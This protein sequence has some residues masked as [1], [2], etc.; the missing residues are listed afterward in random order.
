MRVYDQSRN[1]YG[2]TLVA[3]PRTKSPTLQN[4]S[5]LGRPDGVHNK[6]RCKEDQGALGVMV[7][8]THPNKFKTSDFVLS[9][10]FFYY[11]HDITI[12]PTTFSFFSILT[13]RIFYYL[14]ITTFKH[15]FQ[16][17]PGKSIIIPLTHYS[18]L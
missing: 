15:F 10:R 17:P 4:E 8:D 11:T 3:S 6:D 7:A 9:L 13:N 12:S 16:L 14:H 1:H 18:A 2:N 5:K